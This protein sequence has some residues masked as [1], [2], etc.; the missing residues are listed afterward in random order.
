MRAPP[1][2]AGRGHMTQGRGMNVILDQTS[3][4]DLATMTDEMGVLSVYATADPRDKSAS[5]AW[6]L[7]VGNAITR[8]RNEI[9][10]NGDRQRK[11]AVLARLEALEPELD[12]V[13]DSGESGVGRALFAPVSR[14]EV[15]TVAVQM[16][17]DDCAVLERRPYLRPLAAALTVGAPAGVLAVS[18]EGVRVVDLRFGVARDVERVPFELENEDWRPTVRPSVGQTGTAA[19]SSDQ[20]DRFD[21][22]VED[23]LLRFMQS[24]R[25]RVRELA[26][27]NGWQTLV[28][29]GE[30]RLVE[31]LRGKISPSDKR[32]VV[33]LNRVVEALSAP[34]IAAL[35]RPDLEE[36]RLRRCRELAE[37]AKEAALSGGQGTLGLS[38][39]LGAFR[40]G[41]VAHLILDGTR[42]LP[43]H[44]TPGGQYYPEGETPPGE[45]AESMAKE[46]DMGER[47]IE[48][49]LTSGAEVTVLPEET[50]DALGDV[51]GVAALLR[52]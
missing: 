1:G 40:E 29:T 18:H 25:P 7:E 19:R 42:V 45:T 6:R 34:D 43:G 44:R 21:R 15:R 27:E 32:D 17:L 23:H 28:I 9:A 51:E 5:P 46:R 37:Q 26:D 14:D 50:V 31:R 4:R 47:M 13:L 10:A 41:R 11:A 12:G 8:L 20:E 33:I 36:S 30:A 38:D 2:P 24:V 3:L 35:V 52:W 48:L 16:P 39:T 22:R 49:A